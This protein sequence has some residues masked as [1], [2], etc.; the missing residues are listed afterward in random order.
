M[1]F[2]FFYKGNVSKSLVGFTYFK[3]KLG[4]TCCQNERTY[5]RFYNNI[6]RRWR[7]MMIW[8][9]SRGMAWYGMAWRGKCDL[10]SYCKISYAC[11]YLIA[12]ESI[13]IYI[14][15]CAPRRSRMI[16]LQRRRI[17]NIQMLIS[18]YYHMVKIHTFLSLSCSFSHLIILYFFFSFCSFHFPNPIWKHSWD[19]LILFKRVNLRRTDSKTSQRK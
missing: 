15:R 16:R 12:L 10:K 8:K 4:R 1:G 9:R 14:K 17:V 18:I 13:L 5:F 7:S 2:N 11:V 19:D 3:L 6:T